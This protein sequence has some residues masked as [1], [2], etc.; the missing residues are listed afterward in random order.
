MR[1][2]VQTREVDVIR[3]EN[4]KGLENKLAQ[5]RKMYTADVDIEDAV[6][7]ILVTELKL[8]GKDSNQIRQISQISKILGLSLGLGLE[9]CNSLEKAAKIYDIGN[10][11]I[12]SEV[13]EKDDKLSFEEFEIVKQHT[14]FGAEIL[15]YQGFSST[16]LGAIISLEHHEWWNGGGYPHQRKEKNL[17]MASRIVALADTVGALFRKRPGRKVWSYDKI[18]EY[19]TTR[20]GIQF[21]PDIVDV[22]LI[23]QE[24][25]HEILCTDLDDVPD[26]WYA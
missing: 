8:H 16:D 6:I 7:D 22:F 20:S 9:Y 3:E 26:A 19:I 14:K 15:Q 5:L 11:A 13:Y 4:Q 18:L 25:I 21:D 2:Y 17:N 24:A 1:Q 23:N 10:I 12:C